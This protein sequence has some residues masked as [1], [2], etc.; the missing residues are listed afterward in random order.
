MFTLSKIN[1]KLAYN[2]EAHLDLGSKL[3]DFGNRILLIC[4]L[5]PKDRNSITLLKE[6]FVKYS[7]TFIQSNMRKGFVN[8]DD[9]DKIKE[10]AETFSVTS[11]VSIGG[12]A[13]RM[14]GRSIADNLSLNYFEIPTLLYNPY[15]L[16]PQS[17]YSNRVSD[18]YIK[19]HLSL[20][21][22]SEIHVDNKFIRETDSIG[23]VLTALSIL[24]D[25][26]Q[27]FTNPQNN[28][29][30]I[31]ES[32]NLFN[33]ILKDLEDDNLDVDK[34]SRYG[35]TAN[36]YHGASSDIELTPTFYSWI[37]GNRFNCEPNI[38][39]AKLLPSYLTKKGESGLSLKIREILDKYTIPTR[40][41]ELGFTLDQFKDIIS[42]N[43]DIMKIVEDA[44]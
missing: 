41:T 7:L 2:S 44:F 11:I 16:I 32:K 27:L 12:V 14:C 31:E 8:I 24:F 17:N 40:L 29:I 9:I 21:S 38:I 20:E 23:I 4:S 36:L 22:I 42:D 19:T 33:R 30:S 39:S 35:L 34:I 13:Q 3:Q 37:T 15:L 18:N 5:D 28:I 6:Q 43:S 26:S 1:P 25:L 10:R